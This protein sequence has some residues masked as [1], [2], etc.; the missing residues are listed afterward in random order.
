MAGHPANTRRV[1]VAA[2]EIAAIETV[3]AREDDARR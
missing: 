3:R 2:Y 1:N